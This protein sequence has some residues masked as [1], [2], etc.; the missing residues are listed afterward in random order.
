MA[1]S[2]SRSASTGRFVSKATTAR[3]PSKTVVQRVAGASGR[4]RTAS[5]SAATGRFLEGT[6]VKVRFGAE[7]RSA[8]VLEQR[9]D[10]VRVGVQVPGAEEQ[11]ISTYKLAEINPA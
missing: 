7:T 6:K 11:I 8:T 1:R 10:R 2:V 9:G 5:R 4:G 3:W